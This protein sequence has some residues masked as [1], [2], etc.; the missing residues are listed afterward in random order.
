M[1][2]TPSGTSTVEHEIRI[3]ARPETVFPYFTDPAK[4]VEW[5]GTEAT[6]DPRPGG[7]YRLVFRREFGEAAVLGRF[8]EVTPHERIVFTWGWESDL[9][10]VPPA[11]TRVEVSLL[12]DDGATI[13]RLV[14][15]ELPAD[16]AQAHVAGWSHFME[17][18]GVAAAGG[19]PGPDEW[20]APGLTPPE[21]A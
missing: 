2:A 16:A 7:I 9:F 13:V 20:V 12:P 11:S 8:G 21:A 10:G 14:H 6:A 18:L 17:R 19:D 3:E 5:M 15:H 4:M 1:P